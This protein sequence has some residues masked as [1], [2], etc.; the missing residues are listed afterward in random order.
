[1]LLSQ[2]INQTLAKSID[3]SI[4]HLTLDSRTI[5]EGSVFIA[6]Q[7]TQTHGE[8]FI[9]SALQLGTT[10][11]LK[12]A[13]SSK[14][15]M[16]GKIPCIHIPNLSQKVGKIAAGFYHHPSQNMQITGV[17][18]TNGK[19]SVTH[20]IAQYLHL[21]GVSSGLI[22][23]L[24]Y[25][26]YP[27]LQLGNHTT[28]DAINLQS[29][30]A[31]LRNQ[32][33]SQVTMEVSS[34]ALVQGRVNGINFDTAILT[35]LSQDHLDYH[36]TMAAYAEAKQR[37]FNWENL[38]TAIINLDDL[39]GQTIL[40]K[41]SAKN[42]LTYSLEN[43]MADVYTH[44]ES[45]NINGCSLKIY[46]PWGNIKT[47]SPLFGAFNV[48]NLLAALTMLLNQGFDLSTLGAQLEAI[49]PVSGRMEKI[50]HQA[51]VIIDYAHT[52]DALEK[53]LL[54]LAQ[55]CDD[56]DLWCVFGCG[57]D[58]DKGKRALMGKV[59]NQY[60]D[61]IIITDDNP[62][63]ENS[64]AIIDDILTTCPHPTQVIPN[65]KQAIH[66]ALQQATAQ[67]IILIAGKGHE[68][69]QQIGEQKF[70]FSDQ[71]VVLNF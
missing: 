20:I 69:H 50:Q 55:H 36:K 13:V 63:T 64:Q 3:R 1:M 2:L 15:E 40:A 58:R 23:T 5:V 21:N 67:D 28:P 46:T 42:V 18:G 57:G 10:A 8:L 32:S 59:A 22:G 52:P 33:I 66:Y 48:S 65:R 6:L 62:R 34:H 49:K 16:M 51:L 37:L 47:H 11:I 35:N 43:K 44:I 19:T 26:I 60:A 53:A 71:E 4:S 31:E 12:E 14:I 45:Y 54:T 29:L 30:L 56:G 7:G 39:F 24:G 38:K 70:P 9:E 61:K 41:I 25:G 17:T 68:N 27:Y